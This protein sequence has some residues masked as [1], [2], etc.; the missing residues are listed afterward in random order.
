VKVWERDENGKL[1]CTE[2]FDVCDGKG[3]VP[4]GIEIHLGGILGLWKET[5]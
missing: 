4:E 2:N 1:Q 5:A 3:K